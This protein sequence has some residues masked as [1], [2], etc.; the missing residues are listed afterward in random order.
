[1]SEPNPSFGQMIAEGMRL[2]GL[3]YRTLGKLIGVSHGYL[4]Q[5]VSA[6]KRA[7][8]DPGLKRKRPSE[9]VVRQLAETLELD[10]KAMLRAAGHDV[11]GIDLTISGPTR[12]T[13]YPVTARQLYQDGVQ[14]AAKGHADRAVAL[15]EAALQQG[16][17][18]VVNVH[19]GLGMA[20]FQAGRYEEAIGEFDACLNTSAEDREGAIATADLHYNR[21]LAHQRRAR[22][23]QG[24]AQ[25]AHRIRAGADFRRAIALEGDSQDLYYSALCYMCLERNQARRVL[26]YGSDF[27]HRQTTGH[28]RHTT[29][30]LDIH[31]FMAYAHVSIG[32]GVAPAHAIAMVDITLQLC[33]T[34]WFAHFVKSALLATRTAG[35]A[36]RRQACLEAGLFHV[37]RAIQLHPPARDHYQRELQGDFVNWQ[38]EPAFTRLLTAEEAT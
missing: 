27:L 15:L 23:A 13:P 22:Q 31:L 1:M 35:H 19:A 36:R 24:E 2:K 10:P 21:G 37:R 7:I 5:M 26:V 28:T 9:A 6:D 33:D 38:A 16:G 30:A 3:D 12:Y 11:D 25:R 4:W 17:V 14:A 20:H 29:A 8:N 32:G 18:S 34:Y